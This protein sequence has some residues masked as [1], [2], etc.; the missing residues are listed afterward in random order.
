VSRFRYVARSADGR[1]VEGVREAASESLALEQLRGAGLLVTALADDE[2]SDDARRP[3]LAL[4]KLLRPRP[5]DVESDLR[6][7]GIM[8]RSGLPLL[9]S[10]R[11]CAAQTTRRSLAEVW[12]DVADSVQ[13]GS[14]LSDAFARQSCFAPLIVRL[15]GVG[16]R[17]GELDVVLE[18]GA[19]ALEQRRQRRQAVLTALTY[20]A[21]VLTIAVATTAYMLVVLIPELTRFLS[22]LGRK[23]PPLTQFLVDASRWL[24][25]HSVHIVVGLALFAALLAVLALTKLRERTL[26]PLA[27]R[28]PLVG[29]ILRL[30]AVG[31]FANNMALLL[32]SG[33]RVT[34][35]LRTVEP[36]LPL[37]P[38]RAAVLRAHD[39]VLHGSG[40]AE[41]FAEDDRTFGPML[42]SMVAVGERSGTLDEVL[43][44]VA[45]FHD[46]RL[47]VLIQRLGTIL[48]PVIVVL[49][50]A[51]VGFIY[52]AFFVAVYSVAG[53]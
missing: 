52:L 21:I 39:R 31:T 49:V 34:D 5:A 36:L 50:G 46:K 2:P 12:L 7:L 18:R 26:D 43:R 28:T 51:V 27:L 3:R 38:L 20:P 47:A 41:A 53:R 4:W 13:N 23:L 11:T 37:Q 44:Q 32:A 24:Q 33:V 10:L 42:R 1:T 35:A 48:E 14:S 16:E 30:G 8:L 45:D 6:R 19:D 17:T 29:R 9:G 40:L 22:S 15:T 25:V